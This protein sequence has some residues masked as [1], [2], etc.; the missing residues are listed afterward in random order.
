MS[1]ILVAY[2][3]A[4]GTTE[5]VAKKLCEAVGGDLF[6]ITPVVPYTPADLEWRNPNSRS[7]LEMRDDSSRPQIAGRV[8]DIR[9][10]DTILVG[11]PLWWYRAPTIINTFLETYDLSD[12]VVL[13]FATSGSSEFGDTN[14][15]LL[16]SC[17]D[18]VLK[19]GRKLP[20][21]ISVDG[22]R[23]WFETSIKAV[24]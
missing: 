18:A 17:P 8:D 9:S 16:P 3:S 15:F 10:Y 19:E 11:F 22:L 24:Q 21:N 12:K 4:T 6:E 20:Q 5:S 13:P 14:K 7:S 1:K 23:K 2:F